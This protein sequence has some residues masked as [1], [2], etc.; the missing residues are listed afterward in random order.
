MWAEYLTE[1]MPG[2]VILGCLLLWWQAHLDLM[3]LRRKLSD[4][5]TTLSE[6]DSWDKATALL[7]AY[8]DPADKC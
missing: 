2:L 3:A 8:D 4:L 1:I 7:K 6:A 5:V